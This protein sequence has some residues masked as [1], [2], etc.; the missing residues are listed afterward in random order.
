MKIEFLFEDKKDRATIEA[1]MPSDKKIFRDIVDFEN[2]ECWV[3]VFRTDGDDSAGARLL[4]DIFTRITD[5]YHPVILTNECSA[6]YNQL[7]FPLFN[8]F[9]RKLRKLLYLKSAF[10]SDGGE[11]I[12][13]LEEMELG[14]IFEMLFTDDD[15]IAVSKQKIN[16]K[17]WKYTKEEILEALNGIP[18]NVLWDRLIGADCVP[19]LRRHFSDVRCCRN[20]TVH[21]HNIDAPAF[22]RAQALIVAVNG[23]LDSEIESI[24]DRINGQVRTETDRQFNSG[25]AAA[26]SA[27]LK[28]RAEEHARLRHEIGESLSAINAAIP[29]LPKRNDD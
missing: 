13:R 24:I 26:I 15:F 19:T 22:K 5:W 14:S 1:Y 10:S 7:L 12:S 3:L 29:P 20:D 27:L 9:E 18:E 8:D 25:L 28:R 4:S 21:A 23:E 16:E 6:Y 11:N 2:A 17:T